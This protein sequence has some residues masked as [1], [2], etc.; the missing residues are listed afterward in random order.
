[1]KRFSE[2]LHSKANTVKLRAAEKRELRE[3]LVAYMEYHPL[4]ADMKAVKKE[5]AQKAPAANMLTEAFTTVSIPFS[6]IF[7]SSAVA[8]ALVL[9]VVPFMAERSV[10]GDT[11]YAVKVQFNEELRSSLTFDTYQKVEWETERLNRR[12]AEARLLASEG[13]LTEEVEAEVAQAVKTHTENAQKEIDVLRGEDVDGAT[14]AA[15]ALDTILEVQSNS[16]R[17][18]DVN[19]GAEEGG[20]HQTDL[21]ANVIDQSRT[22]S[23]AKNASSTV[24]AYDK[25]MARVEQNTTRIYELRDVVIESAEETQLADVNR[26]IEDLDRAIAEAIELVEEDDMAARQALVAVLQRTQR[27][28]VFM[29]ELQVS[30][31]VDIETVVP[32]ELTEEEKDVAM[33][34]VVKD[35]QAKLTLIEAALLRVENINVFEKVELSVATIAG[36]LEVSKTTKDYAVFVELAEDAKAL[37]DDTLGILEQYAEPIDDGQATSSD[38]VADEI[39]NASSTVATSTDDLV[40]SGLPTAIDTTADN[41]DGTT[42][43]SLVND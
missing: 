26:R 39:I 41:R 18:T 3:R 8:A 28:I 33:T 7:K 42:D 29:S 6:L 21:I 13:R 10:P 43:N 5:L 11:L 16:L 9:V 25:L 36:F 4:P 15:I 38:A 24:P 40:Q 20:G 2:Q 35:I 14:I 27:L 32:V 37:A 17:G 34:K 31:N 19:D 23:G 22:E 12:I 1:M 30:K